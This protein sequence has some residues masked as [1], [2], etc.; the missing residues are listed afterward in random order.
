M[1]NTGEY[2]VNEWHKVRAQCTNITIHFDGAFQQVGIKNSFTNQRN[3]STSCTIHGSNPWVS[4]RACTVW[5]IWTR[6]RR[7]RTRECIA[8][9]I[10]IKSQSH[11]Y[12]IPS[13]VH[14][15]CSDNGT[16][17]KSKSGNDVNNSGVKKLLYVNA[18]RLAGPLLR[19]LGGLKFSIALIWVSNVCLFVGLWIRN[20]SHLV[21]DERNLKCQ[22]I[23]S[24]ANWF[25]IRCWKLSDRI[26]AFNG[27]EIRRS[28]HR[29]IPIIICSLIYEWG[30]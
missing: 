1:K 25:R 5:S 11:N 3:T 12:Y 28:R 24:V 22:F 8:P 9:L 27:L 15:G 29:T 10:R 6:P 16:E 23:R 17:V 20:I 19:A 7:H 2:N 4:V 21:D 30:P 14:R 26:R 18:S 13:I